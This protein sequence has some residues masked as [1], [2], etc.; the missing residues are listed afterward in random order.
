MDTFYPLSG[1]TEAACQV[2]FTASA[3]GKKKSPYS[4]LSHTQHYQPI[5]RLSY[6]SHSIFSPDS[7]TGPHIADFATIF[8]S[9]LHLS[10]DMSSRILA[11][12]ATH[13]DPAQDALHIIYTSSEKLFLF[14]LLNALVM[15]RFVLLNSSP[16]SIVHTQFTFSGTAALLLRLSHTYH[17]HSTL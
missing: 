5:S 9:K 15:S 12:H 6:H 2:C 13:A 11:V 7:V 3:H 8:I 10:F 1:E 17:P 14:A 4:C 16:T